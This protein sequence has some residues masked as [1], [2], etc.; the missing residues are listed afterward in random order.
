MY[1]LQN[2]ANAYIVQLKFQL[3]A[4]YFTVQDIF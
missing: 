1:A 2:T 4:N 3:L